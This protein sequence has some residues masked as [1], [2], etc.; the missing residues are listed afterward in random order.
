MTITKLM[1]NGPGWSSSPFS[2]VISQVVKK[3]TLAMSAL[4]MTGRSCAGSA[5]NVRSARMPVATTASSGAAMP[6]TISAAAAGTTRTATSAEATEAVIIH[7][8][9]VMGVATQS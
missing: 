7:T 5:R 4:S 1:A 8:A 2:I 9:G 3:I 6:R